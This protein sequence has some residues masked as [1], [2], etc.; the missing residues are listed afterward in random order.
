VS[1]PTPQ[2]APELDRRLQDILDFERDLWKHPGPK[3]RAV[4]E[5]FGVSLTRYHHMLNRA[6]DLPQSLAYDPMLVRRLRRLRDARR[7]RRFARQF[8]VEL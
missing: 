5:R 6:L 3:D 4:R 7:R 2:A 1:V 8:G